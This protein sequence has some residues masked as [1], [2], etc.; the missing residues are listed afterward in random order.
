[1]VF[2][3][4]LL[5]PMGRLLKRD[6]NTMAYMTLRTATA[7]FLFFVFCA[8]ISVSDEEIVHIYGKR[9]GHRSFLQGL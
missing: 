8:D 5:Q 7:N 1:M 2:R 6:D 3:P 9:L 4:F